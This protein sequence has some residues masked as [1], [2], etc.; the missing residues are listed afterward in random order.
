MSAY[1][2]RYSE[3]N[4]WDVYLGLHTQ[5]QVNTANTVHKEVKQI[6]C[7]PEYSPLSYDNDIALME[8]DSPVTLS[9]YIW[10]ICLPAATHMLPAGQSVWVTGWGRIR[11]E[12]RK[13]EYIKGKNVL[14]SMENNNVKQ[15]LHAMERAHSRRLSFY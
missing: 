2:S 6:I 10:P 1:L 3:P 13:Y 15:C 8:L 14:L 5:S 4:Q 12:G 11:E 9:Q 7:H